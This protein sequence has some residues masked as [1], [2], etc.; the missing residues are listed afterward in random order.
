MLIALQYTPDDD[1]AHIQALL[2]N[3][4]ETR[5]IRI[6]IKPLFLDYRSSALPDLR[7]TTTLWR[8]QAQASGFEEP[9]SGEGR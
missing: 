2:S 5:Y 6:Q 4:Q 7:A 9:L 3:F 1:L 8:Q